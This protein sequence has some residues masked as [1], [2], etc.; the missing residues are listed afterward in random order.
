MLKEGL[1]AGHLRLDDL[2]ELCPHGVKTARAFDVITWAPY[3]GE[4]KAERAMKRLGEPFHRRLGDLS[5][6]RRRELILVIARD[7][8]RALW[9]A[10]HREYVC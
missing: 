3:F 5:R 2:I 9:G 6:R 7:S 10:A 8:S 1:A 4:T